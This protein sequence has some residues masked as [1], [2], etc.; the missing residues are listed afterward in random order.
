MYLIRRNV[1]I[2]IFASFF[3]TMMCYALWERGHPTSYHHRF[4]GTAT[5]VFDSQESNN[6]AMV[7]VI[8]TADYV[9]GAL[10]LLHTWNKYTPPELGIQTHALVVATNIPSH[11]LRAMEELGWILHNVTA[12]SK[13]RRTDGKNT[14][15][16]I[17]FTKLK[18][19]AAEANLTSFKQLLY[20][21]SDALIVAPMHPLLDPKY[22]PL[23][24]VMSSKKRWNSGVFTFQSSNKVHRFFLA[25]AD[26]LQ[27]FTNLLNLF[28]S[29]N[30]FIKTG[31]DQDL[32]ISV[33]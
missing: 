33:L 19:W 26:S 13:T 8:S 1:L 17:N 29:D 7:T 9:G 14:R 3:V 30:Y 10:L 5:N 18:L 31:G 16:S 24:A 22:L 32:V 6:F 23:A 4:F 2:L 15:V 25:R 11:A 20:L 27:T 12:L 21:D 28:Y